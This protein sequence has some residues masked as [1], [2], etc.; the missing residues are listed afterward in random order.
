MVSLR[1]RVTGGVVAVGDRSVPGETRLL[2]PFP[3]PLSRASTL[4][5]DLARTGRVRLEVFDL[6][7]RRVARVAD[8]AFDPGRHSLDWNGR[9]DR[10]ARL[11]A[12]L[13]FVRMSGPGLE[14]RSARLAVVR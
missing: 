10:G 13:Y 1:A 3:N 6:N 2:S 4:R 11:G 5:F 12:G 14:T 9:D 8:R 7:G